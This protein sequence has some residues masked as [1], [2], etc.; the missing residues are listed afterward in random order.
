MKIQIPKT[1]TYLW[2]WRNP[3]GCHRRAPTIPFG[4]NGQRDR[5]SR[6]GARRSRRNPIE[7][8]TFPIY[9]W[10]IYYMIIRGWWFM[11][12]SGHCLWWYFLKNKSWYKKKGEWKERKGHHHRKKRKKKREEKINP[13]SAEAAPRLPVLKFS[14]DRTVFFSNG[15]EVPPYFIQYTRSRFFLSI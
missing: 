6:D 10:Q 1:L 12:D 7:E 4:N 5:R 3:T 14:M 13:Y 9:V 11:L 8:G 15:T 2:L